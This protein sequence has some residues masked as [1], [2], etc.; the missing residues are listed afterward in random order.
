MTAELKI[1]CRDLGADHDGFVTGGSVSELIGCV[2]RTLAEVLGSS[3]EE[4]TTPE[5]TELIRSAILQS[6]RPAPRRSV[7]LASLIA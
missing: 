7:M 5:T 4:L 6:A 2:Y 1:R 3:T